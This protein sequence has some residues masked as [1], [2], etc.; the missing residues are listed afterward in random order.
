MA[1]VAASLL[2]AD[3]MNLASQ[4]RML[5]QAGVDWLHVD[6]MDGH[7][8]PNLTIGPFIIE[9]IKRTSSLPLD[10]HLMIANPEKYINTYVQ[11]G[12][13]WLTV[14][15]EVIKDNPAVLKNIRAQGVK[16]GLSLNPDADISDYSSLFGDVDLFLIMSVF[17][18][19]G[20]QA[21]IPATLE[22]ART[23]AAWREE[24]GFH[25]Q[26]SI[27]GGMNLDTVPLARQAG[28]DIIVS[29]SA[30]FRDPDPRNFVTRLKKM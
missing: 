20:G 8:V 19:F 10:V 30:L 9:Q 1:I 13:D 6:V 18:G 26:I 11:A 24:R 14:H 17:A 21:F 22:K 3:F 12:A 2:S 29:G 5:E 4:I 16:A 7:F 15:G 23:A 27:D 25:F 28:V